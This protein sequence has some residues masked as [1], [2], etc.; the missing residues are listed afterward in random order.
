MF[1]FSIHL[2]ESLKHQKKNDREKTKL[3]KSL[4]F[5][6]YRIPYWLEEDEERTEILNILDG[7]P[8]Y[9]DVPDLEQAKT[10]PLPN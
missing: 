5:K 2:K 10:K 7:Q 9:P 6:I 4:G 1:K 3:A 8:T